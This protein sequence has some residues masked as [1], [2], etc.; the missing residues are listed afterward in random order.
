MFIAVLFT[1][2]KRGKQHKCPL[3]D[4]CIKKM[5]Y[6]HFSYVSWIGRQVLHHLHHLGSPT[7]DDYSAIKKE[8]TIETCN[9]WVNLRIIMLNKSRQTSQRLSTYCMIPL[10]ENFL[11]NADESIVT[12]GWLVVTQRCSEKGKKKRK[13]EI[14]ESHQETFE[15][16]DRFTVLMAVIFFSYDSSSNFIQIYSMYSTV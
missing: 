10:I 11:K 8:W 12:E 15:G 9:S 3:T 5:W 14:R 1:V 7:A 16:M 4:E 13:R 2:A 6:F